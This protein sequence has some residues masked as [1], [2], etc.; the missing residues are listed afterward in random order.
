MSKKGTTLEIRARRSGAI[1]GC[2][3]A[4]ASG[5]IVGYDM[6]HWHLLHHLFGKYSWVIALVLI[7]ALIVVVTK[8]TSRPAGYARI[9]Q[10]E[11]EK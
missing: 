11:E 5:T 10:G 4:V 6:R 9:T 3:T 1:P 8:L 2:V 7:V